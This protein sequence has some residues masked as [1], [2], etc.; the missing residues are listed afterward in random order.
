MAALKSLLVPAALC[1][2]FFGPHTAIAGP[3]ADALSSCIA[4][5]STGKERKEL[6]RWIFVAMSVHPELKGLSTISNPTREETDQK[7]AQLA[8]KLLTDNCAKEAKAALSTEGNASFEAAFGALGRLAMQELMAD[9]AVNASFSNY[10]K[11][12]DRTR[13]EAIFSKK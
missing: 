5:S 1:A 4:D 6:A 10:T 3:A 2:A 7:I 13:F 12:L 9:P 11:Y 8:T